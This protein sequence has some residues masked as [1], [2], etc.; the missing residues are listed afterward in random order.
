MGTSNKKSSID[1]AELAGLNIFVRSVERDGSIEEKNKEI[2]LK[3][4][5]KRI[6]YLEGK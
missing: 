4:L 3:Y 1:Y 6:T 2:I 5:K